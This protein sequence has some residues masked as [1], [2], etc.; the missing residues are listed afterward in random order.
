MKCIICTTWG[1]PFEGWN[2]L[3]WYSVNKVVVIIYMC[4]RS[5]FEIFQM[6]LLIHGF[7]SWKV[8]FKT[9][10]RETVTAS[11]FITIMQTLPS[12]HHN[13]KLAWQFQLSFRNVTI[14]G[15]PDPT[16]LKGISCKHNKYSHSSAY[17]LRSHKRNII[18]KMSTEYLKVGWC[19][20]LLPRLPMA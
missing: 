1:W 14:L 10:V 6:L 11:S 5:L 2:M 18:T 3:E 17:P 19:S 20:A 13:Q 12:R 16:S 7:V 15:N 9:R 8:S 4:I